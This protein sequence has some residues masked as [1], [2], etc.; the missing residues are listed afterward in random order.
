[1]PFIYKVFGSSVTVVPIIVGATNMKIAEEYGKLFAPYFQREDTIFIISSDF[2]H[3]GDHFDYQPTEQ[4][5][6]IW[7]TIE[8]MDHQG[9]GLIEKND[10]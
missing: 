9:M 1:M 6:P 3:W 2:C 5:V 4:G 8:K 10:I 7:K